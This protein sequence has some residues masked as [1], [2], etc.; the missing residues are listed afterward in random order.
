M[1]HNSWKKTNVARYFK[2]RRFNTLDAMTGHQLTNPTKPIR[3]LDV[4]C[5]EG[6]DVLSFIPN[7]PNIECYGLDIKSYDMINKNVTFIQGDAAH[8]DY[9]DDYFDIVV[10]VGMLEHIQPIE[11]MCEVIEEIHRVS[12]QFYIMVPAITTPYEPHTHQFLWPLRRHRK[13]H[14]WLLFFDDQTWLKFNGFREAYVKR[15]WYIPGMICNLI[16][17]KDKTSKVKRKR[18]LKL[19]ER[20]SY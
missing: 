16:I 4:G 1:K 5:A 12:K 9:P 10:S 17:Y 6:K 7:H 18:K 2:Q 3:I 20:Y 11:T 13:H 15:F 14:P 8:M 19:W